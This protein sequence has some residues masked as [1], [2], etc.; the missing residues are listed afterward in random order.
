L[1]P[2]KEIILFHEYEIMSVVFFAD[3]L[4]LSPNYFDDLVKKKI[5]KLTQEYIQSS[6]IESAKE[7]I[8]GTNK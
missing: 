3:E 2:L 6:L 5:G 4:H 7:K 1:L 8:Y